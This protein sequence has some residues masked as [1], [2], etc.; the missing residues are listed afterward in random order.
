[1]KEENLAVEPPSAKIA[2]NA[3]SNFLNGAK[4]GQLTQQD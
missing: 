3:T 4:F 2:S 1:M